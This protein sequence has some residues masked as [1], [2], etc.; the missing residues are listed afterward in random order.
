MSKREITHIV[1]CKLVN[2]SEPLR[3]YGCNDNATP[4]V[5]YNKPA[6]N[7]FLLFIVKIKGLYNIR[8]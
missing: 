4:T 1:Y 7:S 3:I 8:C 6:K 5:M 2:S